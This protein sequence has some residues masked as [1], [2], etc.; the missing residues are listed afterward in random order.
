MLLVQDNIQIPYG[1]TMGPETSLQLLQ[2]VAAFRHFH[3]FPCRQ[4]EKGD[5][6][7]TAEPE[8]TEEGGALRSLKKRHAAQLFQQVK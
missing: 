6:K 3:L 5:V 8:N 2:Q 4:Q 1:H 7:P